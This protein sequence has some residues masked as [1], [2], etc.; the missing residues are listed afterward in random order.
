M[1]DYER[2][3]ASLAHEV[4]DMI[5]TAPDTLRRD[6]DRRT[7]IRV[8]ATVAAAAVLVAGTAIGGQWM[9]R[10][11]ASRPPE[12]GSSTISGTPQP[13]PSPASPTAPPGA[14]REPST[15]AQ[16]ANP[17][18]P[19]VAPSSIPDSAFLRMTDTNGS[20]QP[21]ETLEDGPPRLCGAKYRSASLIK[22]R[23]GFFYL[24]WSRKGT[25]DVPSTSLHETI[26]TYREDGGPRFLDELREAVRRCPRDRDGA[27]TYRHRI[28]P[29]PAYG[30]ESI[31]IETRTPAR[32]YTTGAPLGHDYIRFGTV[33]RVG[34]VVMMIWDLGY[35]NAFADKDQAGTTTRKATTRLRTWL[36]TR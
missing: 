20:G 1:T 36:N 23:R 27:A 14:T 4:D 13:S 5:L 7:R 22:A 6:A 3:Y 31:W 26:T 30:D 28:V 11:D 17:L 2:M 8:V 24:Y 12:P 33:V 10:A 16:V 34:N 35:E 29:G 9:L 21:R 25:A 15:P 18:S 32:D 19:P